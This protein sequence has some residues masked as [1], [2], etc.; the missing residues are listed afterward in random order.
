V[1]WAAVTLRVS[2]FPDIKY[3][4][5]RLSVDYQATR[6]RRL[7]ELVSDLDEGEQEEL[8]GLLRR[9]QEKLATRPA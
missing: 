8:R 4:P 7:T 3:V 9:L 1:P 2:H 6:V 5:G